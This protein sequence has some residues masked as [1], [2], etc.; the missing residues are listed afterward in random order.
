MIGNDGAVESGRKA[1]IVLAD[2]QPFMRDGLRH[3]LN[4]QADLEVC[5]ETDNIV[6]LAECVERLTPDLVILEL[7]LRNAD[8]LDFIK[9]LRAR[10][11]EVRIL[12]LTQSDETF[13]AERVLRAG[14]QGYIMKQESADEVLSS[15]RKVLRGE[16]YLSRPMSS[17]L[18]SRLL[19]KPSQ[20]SDRP[21]D[22]LSDREFQ[23]FHMLGAGM[24]N[25]QIAIKLNLSVKTIETYRENIK[26]K[27]GYRSSAELLRHAS[28]WMEH[29]GRKNL[30]QT[31]IRKPATLA[32]PA[33]LATQ[34]VRPE[35]LTAP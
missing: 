5:A 18:L 33:I 11:P 32:I 23:V 14:A 13:Y 3:F 8:V 22:G 6:A 34:S 2:E 29:E 12:V 27:F 17:M 35:R 1:R 16:L 25:R 20:V 24:A 26:H 10:F 7:R 4:H 21:L 9:S 15:V 30:G 19:Q 31:P 28:H